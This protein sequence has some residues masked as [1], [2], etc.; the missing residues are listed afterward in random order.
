LSPQGTILFDLDGTLTDNQAG[1]FR[2]IRFAMG[3]IGF[4]LQDS[5]DLGWCI[6]PPL[7]N[8]LAQLAGDDRALG[9]RA[10]K[11][12]R[13]EY[14]RTGLFENRVYDGIPGAL[15]G[16][17]PS[18][19]LYVATSKL[20]PYARKIVEHFN[21]ARFF[22]GVY[23]CQAD[24]THSDKAELI[25]HLLDREKP[26]TPVYMVGDRE[27]DIIGAKKNGVEPVGVT[28]GFGGEKE[29]RE[30]GAKTILHHP[31]ELPGAF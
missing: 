14:G 12:Y 13:D 31:Q 8:S 1:I 24:G 10:L 9:L 19:D 11:I 26:E 4:P 3:R 27:H 7:E 28:W 22:K 6:G 20:E 23:G 16:L 29:L 21:L 25:A 5:V 18:F 17:Q 2:C 15:S 30:A